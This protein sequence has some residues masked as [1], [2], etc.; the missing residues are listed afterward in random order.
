MA[1]YKITIEA[2]F[3]NGNNTHDVIPVMTNENAEVI[4]SKYVTFVKDNADKIRSA[5]V[6][7]FSNRNE[8]HRFTL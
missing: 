7:L 3:T 4:Y 1:T 5:R 6:S 2:Q 8:V